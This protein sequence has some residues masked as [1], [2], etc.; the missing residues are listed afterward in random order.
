MPKKFIVPQPFE[1]DV[2]VGGRGTGSAKIYLGRVA[3]SGSN[4]NVHLDISREF[5]V[6]ILGK[7]GS[8]KSYTLGSIVEGLASAPAMSAIATHPAGQRRPAVLLL[9]PL[10]NFWTTAVPAAATGPRKVREAFGALQEWDL[11]QVAVNCALWLPAGFRQPTDFPGI[12]EFRVRAHDL[13]AGD[14]ADLC[15]VNLIKEP[16]GILLGECWYSVVQEGY[17]GP[18]GRVAA[19]AVYSVADLVMYLDALLEM[20]GH[21]HDRG[22]LRAL[23]R[24]LQGYARLPLFSGNGTPLTQ[25]LVPGAVSV[26]MLPPRVNH[27]LRRVITRM[28]IRRIL[29]ERESACHVQQRL[30]M[31]E[32]PDPEKRS[33]EHHLST[34]VPKTIL[35]IDEAQE[36]LGDEGGEARSALEDYCLQGRNYGL[37]LIVATQ[38][39]TTAAISAKVRSQVDTYFI[40][41]LLTDDDICLVQKNLLSAMPEEVRDGNR[42]LPFA[43]AIRSLDDGQCLVT[44]SNV[45]IGSERGSGRGFFANVRP[46]VCVHGGEVE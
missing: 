45:R 11:Q 19:N 22:T 24:T 7:R 10:M 26:L 3:E 8:G 20:G 38:R 33:L 13:D 21:D 34:L 9:D 23:R 39:P 37:S 42:V 17:E 43:E 12:Q 35:A 31:T 2:L 25:L 44:S 29:R 27:D 16:Q 18:H 1:G 46:R 15:N 41:R 4:R 40:H 30:T 32:L 28:L 6:L 36:L 5:V 14:W